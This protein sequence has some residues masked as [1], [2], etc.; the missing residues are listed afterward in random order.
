MCLNGRREHSR[1]YFL[2]IS[3][4]LI[5]S[6][7][8]LDTNVDFSEKLTMSM[9]GSYE[10]AEGASGNSEPRFVKVTLN[11]ASL[12]KSDGTNVELYS[13]EPKEFRIINRPQILLEA[14]MSS[15]VGETVSAITLS[16]APDI[17]GAGRIEDAMQSSLLNSTVSYQQAYKVEKAIQ[18]RLDVSLQWKNVI[19][20]DESVSPHSETLGMPSLIVELNNE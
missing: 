16:F 7:C 12:T 4:V 9:V 2:L 18:K 17:I 13:G 15:Y 3:V 1:I 19:T 10:S 11:S 8:S 14:D 6:G 5:S 20:L